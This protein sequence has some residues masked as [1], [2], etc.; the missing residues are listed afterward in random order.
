MCTPTSSLDAIT[1]SSP[2]PYTRERQK[3]NQFIVLEA[4]LGELKFSINLYFRLALA[5]LV[6][7]A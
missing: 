2:V 5:I 6:T 3:N 1:A 4:K 7:G